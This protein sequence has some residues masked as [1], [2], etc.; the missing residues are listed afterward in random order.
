MEEFDDEYEPVVIPP[1][2]AR[3]IDYLLAFLIFISEVFDDLSDFG[4]MVVSITARHANHMNEQNNFA[5]AV[6][7]DLEGIPTKED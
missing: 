3:K 7:R 6:R 2:K 5:D 1:I 4:N